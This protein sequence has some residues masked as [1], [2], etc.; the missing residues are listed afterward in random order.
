MFLLVSSSRFLLCNLKKSLEILLGFLESDSRYLCCCKFFLL[1]SSVL[2]LY[3][4]FQFSLNHFCFCVNLT[5][6]LSSDT[7]HSFFHCCIKFT[8]IS[9]VCWFS[10][11]LVISISISIMNFC[12]Q[13]K[14][15]S[16]SFTFVLSYCL[17][18]YFWILY[19]STASRSLSLF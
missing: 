17:R 18:N 7:R 12:C 10:I 13:I 8:A 6:V 2:H 3:S 11:Q 1:S 16:K 19:S 15:T 4:K 9:S 5:F 14:R